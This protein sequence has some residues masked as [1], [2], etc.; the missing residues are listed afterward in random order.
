[1]DFILKVKSL[2]VGDLTKFSLLDQPEEEAMVKA[3]EILYSLHIIDKESNLT[4][5]GAKACEFPLDARLSMMLMNS[6]KE[7]FTCS[8]EILLLCAMLS[9]K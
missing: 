7:E 4:Q 5:E 1:M 6:F 3:L 8:K 2:G 9:V